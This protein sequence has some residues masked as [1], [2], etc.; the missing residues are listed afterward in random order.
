MP[1]RKHTA[2]AVECGDRLSRFDA[3]EGCS[4]TA[5]QTAEGV[6]FDDGNLRVTAVRNNH[7]QP[8]G[9]EWQSFSF[10]IEGDEQ[11]LVYSVDVRL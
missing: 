2:F 11:K 8:I 9:E 5:H 3:G 6:L 10:L 4:Y 7:M 1:T